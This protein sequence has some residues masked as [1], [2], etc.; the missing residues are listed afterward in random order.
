MDKSEYA[1]MIQSSIEFLQSQLESSK[2]DSNDDDDEDNDDDDNDT[3]DKTKNN[4]ISKAKKNSTHKSSKQPLKVV[5]PKSEVLSVCKDIIAL[6]KTSQTPATTITNDVSGKN[7]SK[8]EKRI[9]LVP[10]ANLLSPRVLIKDT[11]YQYK[12]PLS[13]S[14]MQTI[15]LDSDDDDS[16]D[17]FKSISSTKNLRKTGEKQ[18]NNIKISNN[19]DKPSCSSSTSSSLRIQ[20]LSSSVSLKDSDDDDNANDDIPLQMK[21]INRSLSKNNDRTKKLYVKLQKLP[22]NMEKLMKKYCL[23]QVLNVNQKIITTATTTTNNLT[24]TAGRIVSDDD[25]D[26]D[27][28][29]ATDNNRS[30]IEVINQ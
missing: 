13:T 23:S 24:V 18:K 5:K 11:K 19:F 3:D 14:Q 28:S 26:D 30:R 27:D 6:K 22:Q 9:K 7:E 25:D 29:D 17:G 2:N 4:I 15:V 21:S 20:S 16:S 1:K 12:L 8:D 10:L